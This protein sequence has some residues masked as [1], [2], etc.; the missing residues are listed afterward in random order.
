MFCPDPGMA[1]HSPPQPAVSGPSPVPRTVSPEALGAQAQ[2]TLPPSGL[3]AP[4]PKDMNLGCRLHPSSQCPNLGHV[5]C[6]PPPSWAQAPGG[7]IQGGV[8]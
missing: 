1:S 8:A 7:G 6:L 4:K 5:C 2:V 3:H